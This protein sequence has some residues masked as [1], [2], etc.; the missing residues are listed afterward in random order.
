M[1][2]AIAPSYHPRAR[3]PRAKGV[4][5][6]AGSKAE[7]CRGHAE[8]GMVDVRNKRCAHG[9]CTKQPSFGKA[10]SKAEYCRD[11]AEDWMVDVAS[12]R[13]L[14]SGCTKWPSYGMAGSKAEYCRDHAKHGM[15][16]VKYKR[17]AH[18][19]CRTFATTVV[20]D[21]RKLCA[22]HA[23]EEATARVSASQSQSGGDVAG[24]GAVGSD[25]SRPR[26][27]GVGCRAGSGGRRTSLVSSVDPPQPSPIKSKDNGRRARRTADSGH[28][29]PV[30]IKREGPVDGAADDEE[31]SFPSSSSS[32]SGAAGAVVKTEDMEVPCKVEPAGAAEGEGKYLSVRVSWL[33]LV[34]QTL[35]G[36]PGYL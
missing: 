5:G 18:R 14:H 31:S 3:R 13:C 29:L 17:Y 22:Q 19:R 12:K 34:Q 32:E 16:N 25:G 6:K 23:A 4:P 15:A 26:G 1:P 27:G 7:Y 8:D 30:D 9:G 33:S 10:G 28:V 20:G 21:G 24:G 2:K 36:V 35:A 11:H